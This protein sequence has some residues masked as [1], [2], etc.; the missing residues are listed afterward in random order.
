MFTARA[1]TG[2]ARHSLVNE[3]DLLA[4]RYETALQHSIAAQ[5]YAY[6]MFGG[7]NLAGPITMKGYEYGVPRWAPEILIGGC[8]S[9]KSLHP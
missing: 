2:S 3:L 9:L 7:S 1:K 5:L 6:N 4:E 8:T